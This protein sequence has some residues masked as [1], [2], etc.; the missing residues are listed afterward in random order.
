MKREGTK[1][2]LSVSCVNVPAMPLTRTCCQ[3]GIDLGVVNHIA[4]SDGELKKGKHFGAKAQINLAQAQ[5]Q[6]T[7]KVRGSNRRQRQVEEVVRL[8]RKVKNQRSDAA[9]QLSRQLVNDYDFIALEDLKIANMLRAPKS[10]PDPEQ[11]ET[12]LPNGARAK[13]GLNRSIHDAGWGQAQFV[14]LL[15]Y[16]AESAGRTVVGVNPCY[17]SQT[18][19]ECHY[20]DTGNRVNQEDFRCLSCSHRD[21]ADINAARNILR[22]GRALQASV[23]VG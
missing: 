5:R 15:T 10:R 8:H 7:T 18:C 17:T 22:A 11:L 23:C 6:L 4:T 20:V 9:H 16:K 2:W 12:Y 14:S 13:A 19:A 21:F 3:I 1:W